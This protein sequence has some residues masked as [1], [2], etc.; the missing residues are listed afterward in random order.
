[1][2]A[3][4]WIA[5][6]LACAV[7]GPTLLIGGFMVLAAV[8][9][10]YGDKETARGLAEYEKMMAEQREARIAA[11]AARSANFDRRKWGVE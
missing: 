7:F 4:T 10:H 11:D 8:A 1:M 6:I 9:K 2:D 3:L 5:I